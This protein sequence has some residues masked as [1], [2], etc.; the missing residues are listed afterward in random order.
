MKH[1]SKEIISSENFP[2]LWVLIISGL[3]LT[4]SPFLCRH[5]IKELSREREAIREE[6]KKHRQG[7]NGEEKGKRENIAEKEPVWINHTFLFSRI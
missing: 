7:A 6:R 1:F 5:D 2:T 3:L 4:F